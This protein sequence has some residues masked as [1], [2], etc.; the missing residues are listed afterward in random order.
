M[1]PDDHRAFNESLGAFALGALPEAEHEAIA[2][3][4][5]DCAVCAEDAAAMQ[6]A[7]ASLVETVPT[8]EPPPELRSRIMAVV[9][10]EA[11]LVRAASAR[12]AHTPQQPAR[13]A[14][15]WSPRLGWVA[16]AAALLVLGGVAGALISGGHGPQTRTLAAR[17]TGGA[18]ASVELRG[19]A[20]ELV[21]R[22]LPAPPGGRVYE[23][24][25]QHGQAPPRPAG[26]LFVLRSG[27]IGLPRPLRHGDRVMVTEEAAGGSRRPTTQ[28]I[29]VT[30][31][32]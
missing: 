26:A 25:V 7:A 18:S 5:A 8:L 27:R 12:S 24:W 20:A 28:P 1:N 4:V 22:A 15:P 3:H 23:A 30:S 6:Q 31:R 2:R 10:S 21:V 9:E 32:A 19:G 29:V 16:A 14:Q 13:R 17:S 11:A